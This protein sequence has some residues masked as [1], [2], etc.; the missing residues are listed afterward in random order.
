MTHIAPHPLFL[1]PD[2]S[3][4]K[5]AR[6]PLEDR[7][8]LS[9]CAMG[10]LSIIVEAQQ[11]HISLSRSQVRA[12]HNE[13]VQMQRV[14]K[15]FPQPE[16]QSI[17]EIEQRLDRAEETLSQKLRFVPLSAEDRYPAT[18]T[19]ATP[20]LSLTP[21]ELYHLEIDVMCCE[22]D[23]DTADALCFYAE[24][25]SLDGVCHLQAQEQLDLHGPVLCG[26]YP[27]PQSETS[28]FSGWFLYP[29]LSQSVKGIGKP[30]CPL[31]VSRWKARRPKTLFYLLKRWFTRTCFPTFFTTNT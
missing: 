5:H 23:L 31:C 8:T 28:W 10:T 24:P 15:D 9:L 17:N 13:L 25:S 30:L 27:P 29:C 21:E 20:V 2:T 22:Q 18:I 12:L 4:K 7:I 26:A 1:R 19:L 6:T 14:L 11:T 16:E 3:H